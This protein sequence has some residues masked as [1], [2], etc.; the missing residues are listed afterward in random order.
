MVHRVMVNQSP[1]LPKN[2]LYT[3]LMTRVR[4]QR[5]PMVF[6]Q[7]ITTGTVDPGTDG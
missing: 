7:S 6:M 1:V 4:P 2:P 3:C 5:N